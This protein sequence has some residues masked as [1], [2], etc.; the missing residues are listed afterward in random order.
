MCV[1]IRGLFL[2]QTTV[3]ASQ[4]VRMLT[5][6]SDTMRE[7]VKYFLIHMIIWIKMAPVDERGLVN[8]V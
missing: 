4:G 3:M 7:I 1:C 6:I 8:P 5:D 2:K